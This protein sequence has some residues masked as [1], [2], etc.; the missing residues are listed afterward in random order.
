MTETE[1]KLRQIV[2]IPQIIEDNNAQ[3]SESNVSQTL[4]DCTKFIK[5]KLTESVQVS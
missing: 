1:E 5:D 2:V 3:T 4:Q